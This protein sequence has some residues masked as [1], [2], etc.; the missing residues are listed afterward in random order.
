MEQDGSFAGS[1]AIDWILKQLESTPPVLIE[2]EGD[3]C[4]SMQLLGRES[5]AGLRMRALRRKLSKPASHEEDIDPRTRELARQTLE[6][7]LMFERRLTLG[8][9]AACVDRFK[10]YPDGT[11]GA[12]AKSK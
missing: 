8:K 9:E 5:D 11:I 7:L 3:S 6:K 1:V 10:A 4:P 12:Y 2:E